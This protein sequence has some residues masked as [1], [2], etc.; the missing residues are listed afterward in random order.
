MTNSKGI[1]RFIVPIVLVG[2]EEHQVD[3]SLYS[4]FLAEVVLEERS[5]EDVLTN[6]SNP[7]DQVKLNNYIIYRLL[8][9]DPGYLHP[10]GH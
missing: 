6:V 8:E 10:S 5:I 7:D 4:W 3:D 9:V 1:R 2:L